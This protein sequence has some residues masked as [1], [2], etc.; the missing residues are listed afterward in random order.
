MTAMELVNKFTSHFDEVFEQVDNEIRSLFDEV[1]GE[2]EKLTQ[3]V[4]AKLKLRCFEIFKAF[5]A[6]NQQNLVG[7][8]EN[9]H[10]KLNS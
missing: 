9:P 3:F 7:V 5:D 4:Y 8:I 10:F 1:V 2:G 6:E